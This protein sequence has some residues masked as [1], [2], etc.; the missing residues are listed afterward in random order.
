MLAVVLVFVF[1]GTALSI[2]GAYAF[3]NRRRLAAAAALRQRVAAGGEPSSFSLLRDV[4][5]S[6]VPVLDRILKARAFAP[7]LARALQRAGTR[8][9]AGEFVLASALCAALGFGFAQSLG[10]SVALLA[11]VVGLL[12]PA[13]VVRVM[14]AQRLR[15]FEAQLP[16]ALDMLVNAMRAGFS[17]Q[18]A[19]RFAGEEIPKPLGEEFIRVHEEQRLGVDTR[20]ALLALQSRVDT[21]DVRMF[22]SAMLIQRETGGNLSEVLGGLANLIRSREALRAQIDTLTAEPKLTGRVLSALP[23]LAFLLMWTANG[24]QFRPM[25]ESPAGQRLLLYAVVSMLLGGILL[26]KMANIEV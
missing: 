6:A 1:L 20:S 22:V 23:V 3:V 15:K 5:A 11:G 24:D 13:I 10:Y 16:D 18:A 19:M 26:H 2:V 25:V 21:I 17:F 9:T 7:A 12:L 4:R 8:F 14:T